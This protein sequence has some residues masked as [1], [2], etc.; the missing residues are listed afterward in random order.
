LKDQLA[1]DR[2]DGVRSSSRQC[3]RSNALLML[4]DCV[5][6]ATCVAGELSERSYLFTISDITRRPDGTGLNP[7]PHD[8]RKAFL[9]ERARLLRASWRLVET[10]GFETRLQATLLPAD[11]NWKPWAPDFNPLVEPDGIEPTTS[12]L[13]SRRSPN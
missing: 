2:S 8:E 10:A 4:G 12:C 1:S 3:R 7:G 6:L 9:C 11:L 5:S 13:Q